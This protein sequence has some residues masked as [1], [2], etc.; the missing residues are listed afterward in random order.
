MILDYFRVLPEVVGD[1]VPGFGVEV[2]GGHR[3]A[4]GHTGGHCDHLVTGM[5]TLVGQHRLIPVGERYY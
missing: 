4:V 1:L 2:D 5:L 3:E